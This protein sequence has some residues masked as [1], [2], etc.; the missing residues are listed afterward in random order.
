MGD[1]LSIVLPVFILVG[2]G[3]IAVWRGLFKDSAVDGLMSFTQKFAIP[4]LLFT[5]IATL[6]LGA[7]F[8]LWL[9]AAYFGGASTCFV[10]GIYGARWFF[11]RPWPDCIAMGFT[12]MMANTVL[13][14]LPV[15]ER[16]FG[17]EAL[18]PN[19]AI[20]LF[21]AGFCYLVGITTMEIV[22][23]KERGV[24]LVTT[25]ANAM[26]HNS[27][28]IGIVSGFIVNISGIPIPAVA[29]DAL[30]LMIRSAL[31][32][33]L[34][35][36]G[37]VL[38]RYKPQGDVGAIAM[39]CVLTLAV[40][41]AITWAIGNF[42][43]GLSTGQMRSAVLTAAMAPGINTYIFADMYGVA[44]RVVAT[45]VLIATALTVVGA[46]IWLVVLP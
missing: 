45:T 20:I 46:S 16:A 23:A 8:D 14:G 39:L 28:M 11:N 31:P 25:V 10:L 12:A 18:G 19:Y 35:G 37:G 9:L 33:A 1:L 34:F 2:A 13:L 26:F 36:L 44:R 4:C 27:L 17:I 29:Q 5:A 43:G 24:K 40:H 30:D 22:L 42:L 38:Y 21:N 6:D 41:P 7:E 32:A 3:Y 15:T